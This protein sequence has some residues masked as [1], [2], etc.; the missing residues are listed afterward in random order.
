MKLCRFVSLMVSFM[1]IILLLNPSGLAL[2]T[3]S[4]EGF[5]KEVNGYRIQLS[6]EGHAQ[7]G[8]NELQVRISD[9]G[10]RPVG[11]AT[12]V[13]NVM[14]GA[15]GHADSAL[16]P[17]G[18]AE[19]DHA[20]S[21][22]EGHK[23]QAGEAETS[24]ESSPNAAS[25]H[26]EQPG[27]HGHAESESHAELPTENHG[28]E[29]GGHGEAARVVLKESGEGGVYTGGITFER[30]GNWIVH[31]RFSTQAGAVEESVEFLVDVIDAGPDWAL[32][33]GFFGLNLAIVAAAVVMKPKPVIAK[34]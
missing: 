33:G 5:E 6:S 12:V 9:P 7:T 17:H 23:N 28:E 31:I 3:G 26:S 19:A 22:T 15:E 8:Q 34:P 25:N 20:D 14:P 30:P 1:G 27:A 10:G 13:A 24:Q 29:S 16:D 18:E 11:G 21:Q 32:I 2:A 4:D